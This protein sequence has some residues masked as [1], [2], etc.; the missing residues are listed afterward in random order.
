MS[1]YRTGIQNTAKGH[2]VVLYSADNG[3]LI[4]AGESLERRI[5]AVKMANDLRDAFNN[6][7]ESMPMDPIE[8]F[9]KNH[10][11]PANKGPN[12]KAPVPGYTHIGS[13]R[14]IDFFANNDS[15]RSF[16]K[17]KKKAATKK[18]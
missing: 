3:K 8:C 15:I 7:R 17:G 4:L 18:K 11:W 13:K 10:K 1:N 5:D 2:K 16:A 6:K 14:P 9:P 12:K